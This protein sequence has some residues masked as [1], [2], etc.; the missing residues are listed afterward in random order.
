[1]SHAKTED[2]QI[3]NTLYALVIYYY[4]DIFYHAALYAVSFNGGLRIRQTETSTGMTHKSLLR[5]RRFT[6]QS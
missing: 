4:K 1:M 6:G 3:E 2:Q 5:L